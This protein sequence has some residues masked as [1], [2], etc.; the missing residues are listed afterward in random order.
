[1]IYS[2]LRWVN[3]IALHW[4]YRDIAVTGRYNVPGD[5]PLLI[6][7]NHQNALVDSLI[8]GWVIPR[9]ITMTAKATLTEN[10]LTALL[11]KTLG[12]VPLRRMSDEVRKSTGAPVDR[13]RNTEAFREILD[14]LEGR[15]AI[16]IFPEGKSHN[17]LGLEPLRSG[18]ARL[19]LQARDDRSIRGVRILPVGLVFENKGVPGTI[20][21]V[22]IGEAI[23]MDSWPNAD[24]VALTEEIAVRL[25]RV[26]EEA[27]VPRPEAFVA[28]KERRGLK[29]RLIGLA[30]SWGRLTHQLPVR[31][32]RRIAV[33]R[34]VDADQP[35]MLTI[36]FG[37]GFV[38]LTYV[39]QL[40]ILGTLVRSFWLSTFYLVSLLGGAYW[41][42][43][44]RH[45]RRY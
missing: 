44:E 4:F 39:I 25:R 16:L 9:R 33:R 20:A 17:E 24:H 15:G 8:V 3:G 41:A 12:V 42:A 23:E 13:S 1:M 6:A 30:A 40:T 5:V 21:G 19:A 31:L 26:S 11:F 36:M 7:V 32:A 28:T 14:L 45:A 37:I 38:L 22:N 43:F 18:L 35:A 27:T 34:S 10:P 29:E 2:A